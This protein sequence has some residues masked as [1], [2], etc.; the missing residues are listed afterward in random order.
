MSVNA[1]FLLFFGLKLKF[2]FLLSLAMTVTAVWAPGGVTP[3]NFTPKFHQV[4]LSVSDP[5]SV[6]LDPD[7]AF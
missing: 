4:I 6:N 1:A 2:L 5:D 3:G 7:P